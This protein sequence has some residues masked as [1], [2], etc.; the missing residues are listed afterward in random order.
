MA[1]QVKRHPYEEDEGGKCPAVID[2]GKHGKQGS[3]VHQSLHDSRE[4]FLNKHI[5]ESG[6]A[7]GCTLQP[8]ALGKAGRS[9]STARE[10]NR[11]IK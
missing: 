8:A 4:A 2:G 9:P 1:A 11:G 6:N 5:G 7:P 10:P 3:G